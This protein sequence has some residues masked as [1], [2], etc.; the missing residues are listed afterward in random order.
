MAASVGG[1]NY[2]AAHGQLLSGLGTVVPVTLGP[3]NDLFFLS[4]DQF[5]SHVHAYVEPTV[6]VTPPAPDNTPQPDLGI[7]TFERVN[8]SLARITGVKTTDAVVSALYHA[9]QQ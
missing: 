2:T 4:F 5:G 1:S 7:M 9:S 8:N 3:A 6:V